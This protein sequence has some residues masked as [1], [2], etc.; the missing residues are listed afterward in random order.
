MY[1]RIA[2]SNSL[3]PAWTLVVTCILNSTGVERTA[4]QQGAINECLDQLVKYPKKEI[5]RYA[6]V[7]NLL[8]IGRSTPSAR[9]LREMLK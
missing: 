6:A 8:L 5:R 2:T 7:L 4:T 1:K 3:E 9:I